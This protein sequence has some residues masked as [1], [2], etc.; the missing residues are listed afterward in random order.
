MGHL[1]YIL[2][3][4]EWLL[5]AKYSYFY[6][7]SCFAECCTFWSLLKV[8]CI[9]KDNIS[10]KVSVRKRVESF[11]GCNMNLSSQIFH[12]I[13]YRSKPL[14]R[15]L[16]ALRKMDNSKL[17]AKDNKKYCRTSKIINIK[18]KLYDIEGSL[19]FFVVLG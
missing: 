12:L 5:W 10:I 18:W 9:M 8:Y 6:S 7:K 19:A 14:L 16:S 15:F 13:H 17:K 3:K 1:H 2:P 4:M 11:L